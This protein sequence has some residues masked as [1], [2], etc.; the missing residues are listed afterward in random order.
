MGLYISS[1]RTMA[2]VREAGA[3]GLARLELVIW[4][5]VA[6]AAM[7]PSGL[8]GAAQLGNVYPTTSVGVDVSW[9]KPNCS[10][11][12][13]QAAFGIVGVTGGLDFTKNTCL[14]TEA[15]W[16]HDLS[17]YMNTG[18]PGA[19]Y[20]QKYTTYPRKCSMHGAQCWAYSYGFSA[21]QYALL[22]AASQNVHSSL[23]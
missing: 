17:L 12:Q 22:Y 19:N 16:F 14:L 21:E 18:F 2:M 20:V 11:D 5:A 7:T 23:W 8:A 9:P 4:L 10:A 15:S 1:S 6:I 13:P 3:T